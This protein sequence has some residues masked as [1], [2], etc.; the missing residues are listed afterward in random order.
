MNSQARIDPV[1]VAIALQILQCRFDFLDIERFFDSPG[2]P[3]ANV[4]IPQLWIALDLNTCQRS[5]DRLQLDVAAFDLLIGDRDPGV[6]VT[7]IEILAGQRQ[8]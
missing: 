4:T 3:P 8:A 5:F 6:D 7:V 1:D 2:Q